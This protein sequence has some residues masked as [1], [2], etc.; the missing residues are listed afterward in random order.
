M[1]VDA[2][3]G[4]GAVPWIELQESFLSPLVDAV[5]IYSWCFLH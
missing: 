1:Y 5:F 4:L 2:V 3:P